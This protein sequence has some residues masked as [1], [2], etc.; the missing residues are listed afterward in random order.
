MKKKVVSWLLAMAL[1]CVCAVAAGEAD[2]AQLE[3]RG[4]TLGVR[5]VCINPDHIVDNPSPDTQQ[6]VMVR[7]QSLAGTIPIAD[8]NEDVSVFWLRDASGTE[9]PACAYMPYNIAYNDRS[10]FFMTAMEQTVFDLFFIVPAGMEA[11]AFTLCVS[12]AEV[13]FDQEAVAACTVE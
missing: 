11:S 6:Y 9:Y 12:D 8:I 10:G 7:L 2:M 3:W 4:Y 5:S 13:G 1:L